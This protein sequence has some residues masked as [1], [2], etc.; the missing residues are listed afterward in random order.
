MTVPVIKCIGLSLGMLTWGLVSLV[1]GWAT[2]VFGLFDLKKNVV[3]IV[4]LNYLGAALAFCS[5]FIYVFVKPDTKSSKKPRSELRGVNSEE[6]RLINDSIKNVQESE[7][8]DSSGGTSWVDKLGPFQ[9]RI[10]GFVMAAIAGLFYG[11]NFDPPEYVKEHCTNNCSQNNL[12]YVFSHFTGI[13]LASTFYLLVYSAFMKNKP[14]LYPE[15]ILPGFASGVMWA[16]AQVSWFIANNA[17][18]FAVSFP[19]ISVLP[20]I[21]ATL[22]GVLVFKEITGKRNFLLLGT[23]FSVTIIAVILTALSKSLPG[24][25]DRNSTIDSTLDF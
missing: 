12:D 20:S 11:T 14:Q 10:I 8:N 4:W 19:I 3:N 15:I 9:K 1:A 6:D 7:D 21:V 16:A 5:I 23:A 17:L 18:S 25:D 24:P 13:F 22:W 2:G